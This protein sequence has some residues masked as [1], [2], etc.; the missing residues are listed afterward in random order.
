MQNL[1][2]KPEF[3]EVSV[4]GECTAYS[5]S[6]REEELVSHCAGSARQCLAVLAPS[7]NCRPAKP[8]SWAVPITIDT[9]ANKNARSPFR[10]RGRRRFPAMEL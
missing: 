9:G 4:N 5:G 1:W 3:R 8:P 6:N 10:D 2:E 7:R